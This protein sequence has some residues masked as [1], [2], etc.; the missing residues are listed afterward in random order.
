V[1]GTCL[2][3]RIHLHDGPPEN[4]CRPSADVLFRSAARMF[5][6]RCLAVV[7]TGMGRDGLLGTRQVVQSGGQALAQGRE[8]CTVWGM[9]RHVVEE[10]LAREVPLALLAE[11]IQSRVARPPEGDGPWPI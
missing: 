11:A 2:R 5:G 1:A 3:P 8:S 6:P 9:P 4:S 7:M 10:G